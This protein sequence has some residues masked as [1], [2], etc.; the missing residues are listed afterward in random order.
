MIKDLP[1][2]NSIQNMTFADLFKLEKSLK[3]KIRVRK[4]RLQKELAKADETAKKIPNPTTA[5]ENLEVKGDAFTAKN[6]NLEISLLKTY[7]DEVQ[8]YLKRYRDYIKA[9]TKQPGD[10]E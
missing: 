6:T 2:F 8:K 1:E 5:L 7:L 10:A 3:V 9:H 4:A